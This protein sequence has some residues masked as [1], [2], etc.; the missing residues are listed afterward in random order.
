MQKLK[1][2]LV[3]LTVGIVL[4]AALDWAASAATGRAFV[5]GK[6]NQADH[7]TT[8]K[9]TDGGAAL[10][11][12]GKGAVLKVSNGKRIKKLNADQLDGLNG[13]DYKTNRNTIYQWSVAQHTGGF[14]Q[15]I[16]AQAPGSYLI[17]FDVQLTGAAGDPGNP[18]VIN[19]RIIQN[20]VS[21]TVTFQRAILADTQVTSVS[22]PPALT[23]TSPLIVT[24]GDSLALSCTMTRNAQQ[25]STN[26]YQPLVVNL[27]RTDGSFVYTAPLGRTATLKKTVN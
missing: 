23:G 15:A 12:K 25:W 2:G 10:A 6:W 27:L 16:L 24:A 17:T 21:G 7:T 22:T 8:L 14:S 3:A 1:S 9:N 5:L 19:C 11:L 18:N 26:Q 4:L 20:G 13:S